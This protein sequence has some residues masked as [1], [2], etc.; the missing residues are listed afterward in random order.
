MVDRGKA[1]LLLGVGGSSPV[2]GNGAKRFEVGYVVKVTQ[3]PKPVKR[4]PLHFR[5]FVK[6]YRVS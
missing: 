2:Q 5:P 6:I 4:D 1:H 3:R